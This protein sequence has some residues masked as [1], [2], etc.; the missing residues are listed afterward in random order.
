MSGSA[1]L[2]ESL[3]LAPSDWLEPDLAAPRPGCGR[4]SIEAAWELFGYL[5][6]GI[7][8]TPGPA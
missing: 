8:T 1:E 5:A 2:W 3:D 6:D 4:P 7:A